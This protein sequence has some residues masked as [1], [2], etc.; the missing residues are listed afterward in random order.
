MPRRFI[1][2]GLDYGTS[3]TKVVIR[4]NNMPGR[5]AQVV[6]SNAFK[7]GLFPSLL[8]LQNGRLFFPPIRDGVA[9]IPY[10]KMLP[11]SVINGEKLASIPIQLPGE[12]DILAKSIG[13]DAAFVRC[14]MSFYFAH[15]ISATETFIRSDAG[16][17]DFDFSRNTHDDHLIFQ[18]A[19]PSGLMDGSGG[20]ENLFREALI[21][22]YQLRDHAL[23]KEQTGAP[24]VDWHRAVEAQMETAAG[25]KNQFEWQC[26]IY[27]ETAGAVQAYFR[28]PNASDGL[29]VTMDVG[30]GTVDLNAFRKG[31]RLRNCDYYATI[32]CPL[33]RQNI[34]SP[35]TSHSP[36]GEEAIM[37]ELRHKVNAINLL[38]RQYQP[39]HGTQPG[40]RTW[41]HATFFIFGG[42]A[43]YRPYWESYEAGL[44]QVGIH[45]PQILQLPSAQDLN[46]PRGVDF[47]R[48][49][50][51][52][53][54]SFFKPSLDQVRLP[55]EL[56][57][58]DELYPRSDEPQRPYG[59]SWED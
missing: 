53:G 33:G 46:R 41:D 10:V 42:G 18:L 50:V 30:A 37:E 7:D 9:E 20:A 57:T 2:A 16:W 22:G 21:A 13:E 23:L 24:A 56:K 58:F 15:I 31:L 34:Q 52:Y 47:G 29:F 14:L 28:S 35:L 19:V 39:N 38:A 12:A 3:F 1:I 43:H 48:F 40:M 55:H 5:N 32:V 6:T 27:P 25:N 36:N 51:A 54:L 4:D 8:G 26:L 44:R 59:F 49:A 45:D 11:A 17:H